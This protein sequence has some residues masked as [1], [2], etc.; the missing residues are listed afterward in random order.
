M[1]TVTG[2][3]A[4]FAA[5]ARGLDFAFVFAIDV[6]PSGSGEATPALQRGKRSRAAAPVRPRADDA[7]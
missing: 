5:F 6:P 3:L 1:N 7:E 2:P 4:P